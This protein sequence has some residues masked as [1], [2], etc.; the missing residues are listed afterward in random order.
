MINKYVKKC[1]ASLAV[2][3]MQIK[4]TLIFFP[5]PVRMT[6]IKITIWAWYLPV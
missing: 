3:Y 5:I 6:V 1:S 2:R 4:A